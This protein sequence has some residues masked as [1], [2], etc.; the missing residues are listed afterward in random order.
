MNQT[1]LRSK[2]VI[3]PT[4]LMLEN[5]HLELRIRINNKKRCHGKCNIVGFRV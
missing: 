2:F 1:A 3:L 4:G 5:L